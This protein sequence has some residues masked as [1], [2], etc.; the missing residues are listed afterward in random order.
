MLLLDYPLATDKSNSVDR[1]G[2]CT[3]CLEIC[4]T[5]AFLGPYKLNPTRCISYLTIE[6]KGVIPVKLRPL[7]GNR[8]YGCDDCQLICPWNKFAKVAEVSDFDTRNELDDAKLVDLFSWTESEFRDRHAGSSILRIG[9]DQWLRNI[10]IA[11]G[12]I[13]L[14]K[15]KYDSKL[16]KNK[17]KT[18]HKAIHLL[19]Q[20]ISESSPI[21]SSH[22]SW[23]LSQYESDT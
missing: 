16:E 22:A 13:A 20:R 10:A 9:Y 15:G 5:K 18:R 19:K 17:S 12:N 3:A 8:I 11:L 6:H 1:C 21:V 4:P 14:S 7:I 2:T 23:A